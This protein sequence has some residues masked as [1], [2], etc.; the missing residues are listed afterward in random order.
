MPRASVALGL[1]AAVLLD[2]PFP[3][4]GPLLPWRALIAWVALVPLM[5]GL[6][7]VAET[8]GQGL[9]WRLGWGLGVGWLAGAA[10]YGL[11]CYWV[12]GTM[13]TYGDMGPAM[14]AVCLVLFSLFLG[15]WWGV[16][17]LAVV[18]VRLATKRRGVTAAMLPVLWVAMELAVARVPSF[19]WDQLGMSQIDNPLLMRM[20]PWTGV[21]GVSFVL[22]GV[23]ALLA[24]A[25]VEALAGERRVGWL[26]H[27]PTGAVVIGFGLVN[28]LGVAGMRVEK[29]RPAV[30]ATA[31]LV[32]PNL[33]VIAD[34]TWTA[35]RWTEKLAEFRK[36]GGESCKQYIAGMPETGAAMGEVECGPTPEPPALIAWPESPAPF[37]DADPQFRAAMEGIVQADRA[38]LVV[39]NVGM[40]LDSASQSYRIFNSASV[41]SREGN[42]IGRYDKMHLVPFGEY[43][44]A[45]GLL[46]FA[47]QLTQN[48]EDLQRG[49]VRKTFR[50]GAADGVGDGT[51]HRYGI[52]LCYESVF[53]DE[54]REFTRMGAE[55]LV[56]LS[57]DGWY[58]DT[59]APWQHL[60]MARMRAIENHRW[61]LRDTNNGTTASIDP[62]GTVRQSIPRHKADALPAEFGYE[63]ELTW[64][65][66][67][68]DVFAW[69]CLVLGVGVMAGSARRVLG[70]LAGRR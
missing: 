5:A 21:Y 32:Q 9:T 29:P 53:A 42:F 49:E 2:L 35:A 67:H 37:R 25:V 56:N 10:W 13:H 63:S 44:P 15:A 31:V 45:R 27:G 17:G 70:Q 62:Y 30:Q 12:Y 14:A 6:L 34:N 28:L 61:I 48:L 16:L 66:E 55:V 69:V 59:S 58:G 52:F 7:R 43:I 11:N 18:V 54:V 23:N 8:P 38:P 68:G 26:K 4:A 46:F 22:A 57:D 1:L 24:W 64:Y 20:V 47:K 60:N 33:D 51:A 3:L 41:V 19:P 50:I 40:D 39:G 65:T 36:L